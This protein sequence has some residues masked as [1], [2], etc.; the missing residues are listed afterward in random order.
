MSTGGNLSVGSGGKGGNV[1]DQ[2]AAALSGAGSAFSNAADLFNNPGLANR[3]AATFDPASMQAAS[4]NTPD[5]ILKNI[6][7]YMNPFS[8]QVIDASLGD[9]DRAR[10]IQ[11][12]QNA[13]NA[14]A[15]GAFGGGR[16]G[17]VESL[18]NEAA[19]RESGLLS[20]NLRREGFNTA[21]G[22]SQQD[23]QNL[24]AAQAAN[25][26]FKQQANINNQQAINDA[27]RFNANQE[28]SFNIAQSADEQARAAG[29]AGVGSQGQNLGSTLFGLGNSINQQQAAQGALQQAL[30]QAVM[31]LGSDQFSQYMNYPRSILDLLNSAAGGS[32]LIANQT[33][34]QKRNP[35]LLDW[36]SLIGQTVAGIAP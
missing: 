12:V 14:V 2:S 27:R 26:A 22:L 17:V 18:T 8:E 11:Q 29:L 23:I 19:L 35:G 13:G 28:Q 10:R 33:T 9:I 31:S 4:V 21:A 20:S 15:A 25:A 36:A 24:M 3:Q 16:H 6:K 1:F 7:K 5:A 30:A 32:P 34:T